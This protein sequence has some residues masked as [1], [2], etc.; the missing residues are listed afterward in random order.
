[1]EYVRCSGCRGQKEINS[2]GG[3]RK[4]CPVCNGIGYTEVAVKIE[5]KKPGPKPRG[6]VLQ[7]EAS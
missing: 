2:M 7:C 3:M 1:M 4:S 5:K 6:D